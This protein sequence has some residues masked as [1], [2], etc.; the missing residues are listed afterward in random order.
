[1]FDK[2]SLIKV[3]AMD[4]ILQRFFLYKRVSSKKKIFA[5]NLTLTIQ[6]K[7]KKNIFGG[8]SKIPN[9]S[10]NDTSGAKSFMFLRG[11][12]IEDVIEKQKVFNPLFWVCY[13]ILF[14]ILVICSIIA[15]VLSTNLTRLQTI[16]SNLTET[17]W[18]KRRTQFPWALHL[19]ELV[20]E[21]RLFANEPKCSLIRDLII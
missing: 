16:Q 17:N 8:G 4:L 10:I 14:F 13:N 7:K 9:T 6:F 12:R 18:Y 21:E 20:F 5:I 1:M 11:W 15:Y 3:R 19:W 2:D